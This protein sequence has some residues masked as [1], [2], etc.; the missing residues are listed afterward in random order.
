MGCPRPVAGPDSP[1]AAASV[2]GLWYGSAMKKKG[3]LS[4]TRVK[5]ASKDA[6]GWVI[7]HARFA[8]ISAVEGIALTSG[9]KGRKAELDRRG[10]SPEERRQAIIKAHKR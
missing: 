6:G 3:S 8:K 5:A 2:L 1:L 4:Q 10:A 7:G 9:M